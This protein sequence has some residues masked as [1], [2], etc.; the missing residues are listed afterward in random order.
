MLG[1]KKAAG[2]MMVSGPAASISV[3]QVDA[4]ELVGGLMRANYSIYSK[5]QPAATRKAW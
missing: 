3:P 5:S 4:L 1:L 2:D